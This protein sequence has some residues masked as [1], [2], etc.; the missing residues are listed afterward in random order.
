MKIDKTCSVTAT[1]EKLY[2]RWTILHRPV[3]LNRLQLICLSITLSLHYVRTGSLLDEGC[4]CDTQNMSFAKQYWY[5]IIWHCLHVARTF[6][7]DLTLPWSQRTPGHKREHNSI[8]YPLNQSNGILIKGIASQGQGHG[9]ISHS[10]W[11]Y[12]SFIFAA[13]IPCYRVLSSNYSISIWQ[14]NYTPCRFP[15][16]YS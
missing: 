4:Q 5:S 13:A 9:T 8:W 7:V 2:R 3:C 15:D 1:M 6:I 10:C 11:H 14:C 16:F 12:T